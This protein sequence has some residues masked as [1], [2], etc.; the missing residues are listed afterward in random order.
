[1]P[2]TKVDTVVIISSVNTPI[3]RVLLALDLAGINNFLSFDENIL[4]SLSNAAPLNVACVDV[5]ESDVKLCPR[6]CY[7]PKYR[8]MWRNLGEERYIRIVNAS[9]QEFHIMFHLLNSAIA[10]INN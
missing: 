10:A 8:E 3:N 7:L 5:V 9:K 6:D 1:M 4:C 2:K